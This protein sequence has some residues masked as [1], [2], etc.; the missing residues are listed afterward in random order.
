MENF[1]NYFVEGTQLANSNQSTKQFD[2][3]KQTSSFF[4][5][6]LGNTMFLKQ[7]QK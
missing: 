5:T 1:N 4:F 3:F 2:K 6:N 7:L